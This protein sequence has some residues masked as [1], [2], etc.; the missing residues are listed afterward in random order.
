MT[1]LVIYAALLGSIGG[2]LKSLCL[3]ISSIFYPQGRDIYAT[4]IGLYIS[5]TLFVTSI[6][7]AKGLAEQSAFVL[8]RGALIGIVTGVLATSIS[9]SVLFFRVRG[10]A[11]FPPW[12]DRYFVTSMM[13]GVSVAIIYGFG[14]EARRYIYPIVGLVTG[15]V[16]TLSHYFAAVLATAIALLLSRLSMEISM[17][18]ATFAIPPI[19]GVAQSVIIWS[20]LDLVRKQLVSKDRE[21]AVSG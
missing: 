12:F 9:L 21:S 16:A 18:F 20:C 2:I 8:K 14:N 10:A 17:L 13:L 7:L 6:C 19:E 4:F 11:F 15:G 1:K 5:Q 3:V